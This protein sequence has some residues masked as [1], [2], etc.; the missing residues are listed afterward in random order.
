VVKGGLVSVVV[1]LEGAGLGD[2][3]VLGL[4]RVQLGQ[5]DAQVRQVKGRHLLVQLLWQHVDAELVVA[6]VDPELNL[7]QDLVGERVGH[8]E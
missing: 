8:D 3:Q 2:A 6:G 1:G 4:V 7:C 5:V